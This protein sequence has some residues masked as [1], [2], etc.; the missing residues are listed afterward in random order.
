MKIKIKS[1]DIRQ[2][3]KKMSR[4]ELQE[5]LKNTRQGVG[6]H[7]SKKAYSRKVKHGKYMVD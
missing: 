7:K 6:V 4:E 1:S 3:S 5:H 2:T